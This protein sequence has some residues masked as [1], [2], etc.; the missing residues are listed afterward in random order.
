MTTVA[1]GPPVIAEGRERALPAYW[2]QQPLPYRDVW[3]WQVERARRRAGG[4]VG[5]VL[6]LL[7][8]E[9]VYTIGPRGNLAHLL[10][11]RGQLARLGIALEQVDRGGDITYHG[12]GQLVG[13]PVVRLSGAGRR[14]RAYIAALEEALI[15]TAAYFG[16]E[17]GRAPGC[18]GVWVGRDK[19]AAIG[20][21]VT[22]GIAYHGFALNVGPDLSPF[23]RI[24]PCGLRDRGVTSLAT[25]VGRDIAL[26]EV[27]A[28]AAREIARACGFA[29]APLQRAGPELLAQVAPYV[30]ASAP[31][32]ARMARD[33]PR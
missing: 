33:S 8:H 30:T 7:E 22:H 18:T 29:H 27:A 25:R 16:V 5:D 10:V 15:A 17:A 14:V 19:L 13:Y 12:P 31:N 21:R 24:V 9:P 32:A 2:F 26:D 20:V 28:V 3:R 6:L 1:L 23:E 11:E 4:D